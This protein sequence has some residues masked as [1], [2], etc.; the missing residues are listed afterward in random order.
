MYTL[1]LCVYML[2][3]CCVYAQFSLVQLALHFVIQ[4]KRSWELNRL[5][6]MVLLLGIW[7]AGCSW[8]MSWSGMELENMKAGSGVLLR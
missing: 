2:K 7:E 3:L 6:Y 4:N 8:M 5:V 1:E